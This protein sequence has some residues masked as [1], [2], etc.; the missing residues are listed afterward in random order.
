MP[1][2]F[3]LYL[4][5]I[6]G[7]V[8]VFLLPLASPILSWP[9]HKISFGYLDN[10]KSSSS[11]PNWDRQHFFLFS[12][13]KILPWTSLRL[14]WLT[15]KLSSSYI[16]SSTH[17][18][19]HCCK[20]ISSVSNWDRQRFFVFF[21]TKNTSLTLV[22]LPYKLSSDYSKF[23]SLPQTLLQ[24]HSSNSNTS[25]YCDI[26]TYRGGDGQLKIYTSKLHVP[27]SLA[28]VTWR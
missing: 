16:P 7:T 25:T 11:V 23:Y 17:F 4:I 14:V 6:G 21:T 15:Y 8:C 28:F 12:L 13:L 26:V 2:I 27:T 19:K 10:C 9:R 5:E 18:P 22:G 3:L 24:I 1:L 20:F